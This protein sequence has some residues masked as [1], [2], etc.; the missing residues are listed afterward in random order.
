MPAD[1]SQLE[2]V[3]GYQH[4][5]AVTDPTEW[6]S[7]EETSAP[8][9]TV[10]TRDS[11]VLSLVNGRRTVAEILL[12]SPFGHTET[13]E[14]LRSLIERRLVRRA[15]GS[16]RRSQPNLATEGNVVVID[17]RHRDKA[18]PPQEAPN[19]PI[20]PRAASGS[21][22]GRTGGGPSPFRLGRY[23][24]ATRIGQGGMGSIY[25]CRPAGSVEPERLYTLKVVRQYAD[26]A[27]V[28]AQSLIREGRIAGRL[29][30]PNVQSVVETG[31]YKEQPFLILDYVA[32]VNLTDVLGGQRRPPPAVIVSI[33]I[34]VLRGLEAAHNLRDAHGRLLG[35][36]HGDVSPSNV[37]VGADGLARIT[38]FG[39]SWISSDDR[40]RANSAALGKPSYLAPEQLL[41]DPLDARTDLFA[42]G[43]VL[44]VALTGHELFL[45]DTYEQVA[46]NVLRKRIAPPS[47][48]GA[49]PAV[50]EVCMRALNRSKEGRFQSA[51]EMAHVLFQTAADH[52]LVASPREVAAY[53]AREFGEVL[54]E[55]RRR[56][57]QAFEEPAQRAGSSDLAWDAPTQATP[58]RGIPSAE[59]P[60]GGSEASSL[61]DAKTD[62]KSGKTLAKTLFVPGGEPVPTPR[63]PR[64]AAQRPSRRTP[65][66][67]ELLIAQRPAVIIALAIGLTTL[68]ATIALYH[69]SPA[70]GPPAPTSPAMAGPSH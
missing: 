59:I 4:V 53:M 52:D 21:G 15:P 31:T 57:R 8:D 32:G 42:V 13:L 62:E 48:L 26:H 11:R 7:G 2:Q 49:P 35:L 61:A 47:E 33:M 67:R 66:L 23:E 63:A 69:P 24:V 60:R 27:E 10:R 39:S 56:I 3:I 58:V 38:D 34:D 36:V 16:V 17:T 5:Y 41:A 45:A 46:M 65:T 22:D 6:A 64:L 19:F 68:V 28:A 40:A 50:D 70:K 9:P 55:Q 14:C 43:T 1:N 44:Y 54:E 25:V 12:A 18:S 20:L 30:H 29:N 37:L 51:A